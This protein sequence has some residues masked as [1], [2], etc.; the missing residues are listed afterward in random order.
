M[1]L[2]ISYLFLQHYW[3][4]IISLLA[5]ILVFLLFV[6]G[7]QTL[8]Y[9]LAKTDTERS[10]LVNS[11]GRKWEFTFTTLVVFGG[12][13]F[14]AFPL[15][16]ASSFGGAYAAWMSVLFA[17][18]I[19]AI[20]YEYRKKPSNVFG[21][22]TYEI[23]LFINGALGT[24][25]LGTVVATL[26]TGSS[27][28]INEFNSVQWL[29]PLRG[30]EAALNPINSCLGFTVFFLSRTLA[31]L[32][33]MNNISHKEIQLRLKKHLIINSLFFLVL[34]LSFLIT[35]MLSKGYAYDHTNNVISLVPYKYLT[36]LI[37]M[38]PVLILLLLGIVLVLWGIII[39]LLKETSKGI[40]F[41]GIGVIITV[42]SLFLILGFN[43]TAYYPSSV[44]LQSSLT[45]E[46]SSSSFYTLKAMSIVSLLIPFVAV[47]MFYAWKSINNKKIDLEELEH[48][49]H[50]Y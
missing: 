35:I 43:H 46:N 16:Y 47:Y 44:D 17:F 6:Q 4:I 20:S 48:E 11:L 31:I 10:L 33:F 2:S 5:G 23:F 21:S 24:I 15:F 37:Q 28:T 8:L 22:L 7:G 18:V 1:L 41:S 45:I 36:N 14:A 34:F 9:T 40:W 38:I 27:F 32:Y 50:N 49:S 13:F 26:F 39:S 29:N 25:L 42:F 3:W 19:Q 30:L 12:A